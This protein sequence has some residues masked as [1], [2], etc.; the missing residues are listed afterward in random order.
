MDGLIVGEATDSRG[1]ILKE[2]KEKR[3]MIVRRK[4]TNSSH[5]Y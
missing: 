5:I 1:A 2:G 4:F 3:M